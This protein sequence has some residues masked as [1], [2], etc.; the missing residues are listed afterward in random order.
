M[1]FTALSIRR[2]LLIVVV[3]SL[4][5]LGVRPFIFRADAALLPNRSVTL[6]NNGPSAT[7]TYTFAFD[8]MSNTDIGS[9]QFQFCANSPIIG[10]ACDAPDSFDASGA[11]L[12]NQTG[13]L[14]FS[15]MN[16]T[17][18]NVIVL[19]RA[20][21]APTP[22]PVSYSFDDIANP[23]D[24]GSYY[25]RVQTFM[26]EDATGPDT[27]YGGLAYAIAAGVQLTTTVPPFLL[28]CSGITISGTDCSTAT[29]NYINFGELSANAARTGS[30]QMVVATNAKDG[31]TLQMNGTTM[32]SGTNSIPA[33][34]AKD[35]S[36]PGTSQFGVNLRNNADPDAGAN[37][38]GSGSGTVRAAYNTPNRYRFVP[39]DIVASSP[40]PDEY[41][42]YTVTYLVN[43][44]NDQTPGIYVSTISYIALA[45]F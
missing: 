2:S 10:T 5:V 25:V 4:L 28:F 11:A 35:V 41:R 3:A 40:E 26:T 29:G 7:S 34:T 37:P 38:S 18:A 19:T 31:Y 27:D 16:G 45:S 20:A 24:I 14:G 6:T 17:P 15:I 30:T 1:R 13:E 8:L 22:G 32:L 42:K 12:A 23:S 36:R 44:A 9:I 21:A 39:G 43:I 33:L